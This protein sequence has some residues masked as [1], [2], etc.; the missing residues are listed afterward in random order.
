MRA[1]FRSLGWL[2]AAIQ[3]AGC[4]FAGDVTPPPGYQTAAAEITAVATTAATVTPAPAKDDA[5]QPQIG[6]VSGTL[7]NITSGQPGAEQSEVSLHI[8]DDFQESETLTTATEADGSFLFE[9]IELKPRRAF[10]LSADYQGVSYGSNV[11]VVQDE[12]IEYQA[13]IAV[14][15]TTT[16]PGVISIEQLHL[17][18]EEDA[19]NLSITEIIALSNNSDLTLVTATTDSPAL[20]IALPQGA[21]HV[22]VDESQL[23]NMVEM[24][25]TSLLLHGPIV[26]ASDRTQLVFTFA[27]PYSGEVTFF[28][29]P[30][31]YPLAAANVL[32]PTGPLSVSGAGVTELGEKQLRPDLTV[33]AYEVTRS[34]RDAP[35]RFSVSGHGPQTPTWLMRGGETRSLLFSGASLLIVMIGL[36]WWWRSQTPVA[37]ADPPSELPAKRASDRRDELLHEIANLDLGFTAGEYPKSDYMRERQA[38]KSEL[39]ALLTHYQLDV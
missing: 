30:L 12:V 19:Q 18:V 5:Q 23:R 13:D 22:Q 38:L 14:F 6:Q 35:L 10:V 7:R 20:E 29:Q 37:A 36:T 27:L 32:L 1:T 2:P 8:Y 28:E 17:I 3:L 4:S 16:N 34:G 24:T 26:P 33:V 21:S 31:D 11:L 15:E 39:A 25:A 9:N